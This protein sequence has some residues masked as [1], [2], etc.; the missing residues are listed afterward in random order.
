MKSLAAIIRFYFST[1][2]A[3]PALRDSSGKL[4]PKGLL[5]GVGTL[6]LFIYVI[7]VFGY[8]AWE[9]YSSLYKVFATLGLLRLM[10]VY[11]LLYGSL[12]V[13]ILSFVSSF[14]TVYTNEMETYLA[15]LPAK[16]VFL[17]AGKA[18]A[19]AVPQ[20]F[21]A[22]LS[23]GTGFL[24]YGISA[25]VSA[26]F[27]V[28]ALLE[29]I[30]AV[31]VVSVLGYCI[32][33]PLLSV[34]KFFRNRDRMLV[35]IGLAMMVIILFFNASINRLLASSAGPEELAVLLRG[36]NEAFLRLLDALPPLQFLLGALLS[37]ANPLYTLGLLACLMSVLAASYGLLSVLA[38]R[39]TRVIQ[40]F[41]EQYVRRMN[42]TQTVA[43]LK[44]STARRGKLVSLLLRELWS[45]NREPVYFLNGPFIIV[46][47]P[48]VIAVSLV[49]S[50][51]NQGSLNELRSA[52][53]SLLS[54]LQQVLL[55]SL[56]GAFLGSA[57]SITCTAL[58]RDAKHI[59][60]M[61]TLPVSPRLYLM[62]KLLHGLVFGLAG[63]LMAVFL[64]IFLFRFNVLRV[65]LVLAASSTLSALFNL[66]GLYID[67]LNPQLAWENPVAAMKQNVNAVVMILLE[68]L[69]LAGTGVA[70]FAWAKT[71]LLLVLIL[72]V[73]P[74]LLF[75]VL[76]A[77]YLPLGEQRLKT[78]E[79]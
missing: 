13:A 74:L 41:S 39:Y 18:L 48:V 28:N 32:S 76:L 77:L 63:S 40:G 53:G 34:S 45:M 24:I 8:M 9:V 72:V 52:A 73:L 64:G 19:L 5:K 46:L 25:G 51:G 29:I 36:S 37:A 26:L 38:P 50:L 65:L 33:I 16:P 3:L 71:W 49:F 56:A 7:G 21:I 42:R 23:I 60:Y 55:S 17:L 11:A 35:L 4:S 62:A 6:A 20:F 54:P 57:T 69:I 22:L 31:I 75:A 47:M 58:S 1:F 79:V 14:S 67:T 78:L 70:A 15:T 10:L 59:S 44:A 30:L 43:F 66:A 68:M 2:Y 61:K 12:L 27:Y